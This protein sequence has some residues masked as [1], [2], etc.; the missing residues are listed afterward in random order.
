MNVLCSGSRV[1]RL[2]LLGWLLA[3]VTAE[4][5][6]PFERLLPDTTKQFISIPD[7]RR[8]E[9][10]WD[11]SQYGRFFNDPALKPF[12]DDLQRQLPAMDELSALLGL[13]TDDL[14]KAT[15]GESASGIV[16]P[17]AGQAA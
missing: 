11:K 4:A 13:S 16:Q 15:G 14:K 10:S 7:A 12:M 6:P 8:L 9:E 5:A 17:K 2:V 1:V 3:A